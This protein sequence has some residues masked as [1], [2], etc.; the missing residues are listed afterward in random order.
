[1]SA[2]RS[3]LSSSI[4]TKRLSLVLWRTNALYSM[5]T[6]RSFVLSKSVSREFIVCLSSPMPRGYIVLMADR[7]VL[8]QQTTSQ[9]DRGRCRLA[10]K[11]IAR[12]LDFTE[13]PGSLHFARR[14][15]LG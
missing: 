1:M 9:P 8:H 3:I 4:R 5:F 13:Q 6:W 12:F 14:C 7:A 11:S 2:R 10:V 15:Q